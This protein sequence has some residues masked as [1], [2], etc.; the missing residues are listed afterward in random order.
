[1]Q[2]VGMMMD[3]IL[4]NGGVDEMERLSKAKAAL[5]YDLIDESHGF[6]EV[7]PVAIESRSR[8]NVP[9]AVRGNG[10]GHDEDI[11]AR[12]LIDAWEEGIVGLRTITPFGVGDYLRASLYN[13]V[14]LVDTLRLADFMKRFMKI[15]GLFRHATA[16]QSAQASACLQA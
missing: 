16:R 7:P 14:N 3:W 11:T 2:V 4:R 13:G 8:M 12:F 10:G 5:L 1:V 6:Y 15:N 9:F